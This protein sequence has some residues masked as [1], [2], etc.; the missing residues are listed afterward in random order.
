MS[1]KDIHTHNHPYTTT[2][3]A[4]THTFT[5]LHICLFDSHKLAAEK[6]KMGQS[7]LKHSTECAYGL[8]VVNM[9]ILTLA[10]T[11]RLG[12]FSKCTIL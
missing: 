9:H 10:K 5:Q 3:Q 11:A 1:T 12:A 7:V 4:D 6:A 8:L 2:H